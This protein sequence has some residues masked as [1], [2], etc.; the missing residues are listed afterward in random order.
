M[1]IPLSVSRV[2]DYISLRAAV[3]IWATLVN[4]QTHTDRHLLSSYILINLA[5]WVIQEFIA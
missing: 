3:M 1:G 5:S 4:T 2:E